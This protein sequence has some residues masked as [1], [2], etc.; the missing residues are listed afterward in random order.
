MVALVRI[1]G[2]GWEWM[3]RELEVDG[4]RDGR[5][6][7]EGVVVGQN[8]VQGSSQATFSVSWHP[9]EQ[10]VPDVIDSGWAASMSLP[11][12]LLCALPEYVKGY[13]ARSDS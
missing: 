9:I 6:G 5:H 4:R 2:M 8:P 3:A 1:Q 10:V 12:Q 7:G 11:P 13:P